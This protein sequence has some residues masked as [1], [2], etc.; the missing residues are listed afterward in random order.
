M[1]TVLQKP[2]PHPAPRCKTSGWP[3]IK[4]GQ[5]ISVPQ[6][7]R[8]HEIIMPISLPFSP[9]SLG[10]VFEATGLDF[11]SGA[12][13]LGIDFVM[14]ISNNGT[15]HTWRRQPTPVMSHYHRPQFLTVAPVV[16]HEAHTSFWSFSY[17]S[18]MICHVSS[19]R[20]FCLRPPA[21]FPPAEATHSLLLTAHSGWWR[22][23]TSDA[24]IYNISCPVASQ[25]MEELLSISNLTIPNLT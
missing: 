9:L 5:Q 19:N 22:R 12:R 16:L 11:G 13:S 4:P 1:R 23:V 21:Y 7:A 15:S 2:S 6:E 20:N 17:K 24:Q 8:Q 3:G 10:P 25:T 14:C 18:L